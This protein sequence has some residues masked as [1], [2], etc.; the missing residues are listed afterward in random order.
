MLESRYE[1]LLADCLVDTQSDIGSAVTASDIYRAIIH[2]RKKFSRGYDQL[3]GFHLLHAS[4]KLLQHP[5]LFYRIIFNSDIVPDSFCSGTLTPVPKKRKDSRQ[6]CSY[7]PITVSSFLCKLLK[8][9]AIKDVNKASS[10]QD[11][12]FGFKEGY[13]REHVH[14]ILANV[15]KDIDNSGEF[16][17]LVAHDVSCAFDSSAHSHFLYCEQQRGF[18]R[19]VVRVFK[20]LYARLCVVMKVSTRHAYVMSKAVI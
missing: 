15:L 18:N 13:S 8:L 5:H 12:Q 7:R 6:C 4:D 14:Y 9:L 10:N 19:S 11:N 3:C 1:S 2:L 16:L 17:V 20:N